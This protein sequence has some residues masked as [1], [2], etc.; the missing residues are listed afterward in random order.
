[1]SWFLYFSSMGWLGFRFLKSQANKLPLFAS[2]FPP[3]NSKSL[4]MCMVRTSSLWP[5]RVPSTF[6]VTKSQIVM[7]FSQAVNIRFLKGSTMTYL[8]KPGRWVPER[9]EMILLVYK[10]QI[11]RL[12]VPVEIK[13][14]AWAVIERMALLWASIFPKHYHLLME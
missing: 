11:L 6:N 14:L 8:T 9:S 7:F 12:L 3:V 5:L 4:F 10:S 1:M 2:P 13:M